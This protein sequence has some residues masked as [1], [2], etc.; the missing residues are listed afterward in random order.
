MCIAE[1][2]TAW[3]TSLRNRTWWSKHICPYANHLLSANK[4]FGILAYFPLVLQPSRAP[5]WLHAPSLSPVS[6]SLSCFYFIFIIFFFS[7]PSSSLSDP[8]LLFHSYFYLCVPPP[9][10]KG[11]QG[12]FLSAARQIGRQVVGMSHWRGTIC[13]DSL[14]VRKGEEEVGARVKEN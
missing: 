11:C 10:A 7:P 12:G 8:A 1:T 4:L 13:G 9:A 5:A 2:V 14:P 6:L 3:M